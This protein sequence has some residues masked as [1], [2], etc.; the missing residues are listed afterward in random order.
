MP[1]NVDAFPLL[2][3]ASQEGLIREIAPRNLVC[4]AH[5]PRNGVL[6]LC[7][8]ATMMFAGCK[9]LARCL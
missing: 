8:A 5:V 6:V 2:G 7:C 1:E 3:H 4:Y 9:F